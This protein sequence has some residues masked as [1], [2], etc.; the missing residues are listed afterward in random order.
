MDFLL[1]N[2]CLRNENDKVLSIGWKSAFFY[3]CCLWQNKHVS[4]GLENIPV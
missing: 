4:E 2:S 1:K 3:C